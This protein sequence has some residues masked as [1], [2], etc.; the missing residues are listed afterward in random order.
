MDNRSSA[1]RVCG[2]HGP[3][4]QVMLAACQQPGNAQNEARATAAEREI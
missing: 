2:K 1:A 4:N 3:T